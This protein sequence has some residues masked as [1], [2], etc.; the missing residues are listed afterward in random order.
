MTTDH[1]TLEENEK[2]RQDLVNMRN[3]GPSVTLDGKPVS[4]GAPLWREPK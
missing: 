4:I 2:L 3:H 1:K